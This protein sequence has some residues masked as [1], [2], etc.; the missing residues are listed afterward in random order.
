MPRLALTLLVAL[1]A[2]SGCDGCSKKPERKTERERRS[3]EPTCV[4]N[5]DC[6]D[7]KPC[8]RDECAAGECVRAPLPA[9]ESCDDGDVCNGVSTCDDSGRCK[10]GPAPSFDDGNPCTEDACDPVRGPTHV[11]VAVDDQD[12]CTNDACN[13]QTGEVTHEPVSIDDGDDCTFDSCDPKSGPRHQRSEAFHTCEA[14][15]GAGFH[16]ASR[17][18]SPRCG[19]RDALETF[20]V[21]DC[22]KSFHS[23]DANCPDRYEK[24]GESLNPRCGTTASKQVF[25]VAK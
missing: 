14:A 4:E 6:D 12:V 23:C 8:T 2:L 22:G 25:C 3:D 18:A 10:T 11:A 1:A 13:S 17:A 16:V 5:A 15:C 9:G 20:C 19:A 24:R 21:P 7:G